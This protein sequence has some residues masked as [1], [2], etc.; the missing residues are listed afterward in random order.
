MMDYIYAL[1]EAAEAARAATPLGRAIFR[2]METRPST[3]AVRYRRQLIAALIDHVAQRGGT[4]VLALAAGHLREVARSSAVRDGR[5]DEFVA[6]DQDEASLQVIE[7]DYA[8]LGI[9]TM[10]GSVRQILSGKLNPG[11]FDFVYAAGLYDYL[12][13]PV[14]SALTRRIFDI[15]RPGGQILIPN[16]ATGHRD[17]GYMESF[18]DWHLIYRNHDEM[19]GLAAAL[20]INALAD[21]HI[22][23]DDDHAITYL[24]ISKA[25]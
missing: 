15:T 4:S 17:S 2:F 19:A 5:I 16:F 18:M 6:F 20:P 11:Q 12:N 22:F 3:R 21:W 1:G 24:L 7:H 23:D 10:P 25:S 14:A 8:H 9:R 13:A